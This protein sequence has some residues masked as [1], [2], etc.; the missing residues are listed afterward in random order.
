MERSEIQE[1]AP[2]KRI[3]YGRESYYRPDPLPP[4]GD[5]ALDSDFYD[6][7]ADAT[8]WLGKLS[9]VSLELNVPSVLYTSLLRKEAMESTEIEGADVDYNALYSLE[10]RSLDEG[11]DRYSIERSSEADTKDTQE[12]LNYEQAV[13]DGIEMLD[14]GGE[15]SISLLHELH[16]TL[17]TDVPDDRVD[18]DTIGAY[19][20]VPN[21]LGNFLPP[22]PGEVDGLMDALLTSS[23]P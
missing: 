8:F 6:L 20:A 21:H 9:G 23:P 13:E 17:L 10:T 14:S 2:G 22:V 18:T 7:L 4:S 1:T 3:S 11:E 19:K 5:L 16:E 12:V 15:I